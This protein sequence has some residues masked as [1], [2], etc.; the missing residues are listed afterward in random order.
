MAV[1]KAN[2]IIGIGKQSAFGTGVVPSVWIQALGGNLD[3][4]PVDLTIEEAGG[5]DSTAHETTGFDHTFEVEFYIR[6]ASQHHKLLTW[7]LMG[8]SEGGGGGPTYAHTATPKGTPVAAD[9]LSVSFD[10][11]A[12]V[13]AQQTL[14]LR[15]AVINEVVATIEQR[16]FLKVKLSGQGCVLEPV[17]G[18]LSASFPTE[19]RYPFENYDVLIA[20]HPTTPSSSLAKANKAVLTFKNNYDF[21]YVVAGETQ[22]DEPVVGRFECMV[23]LDKMVTASDPLYLAM[24]GRTRKNVALTFSQTVSGETHSIRADLGYG[25]VGDLSMPEV[26]GANERGILSATI[27]GQNDGSN[28]SLTVVTTDDAATH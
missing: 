21:S 26:S 11:G 8:L 10:Y 22:P 3:P 7:A 13:G 6:A 16:D 4:T 28:P 5:R 18:A 9:L 14:R 23:A 17:A 2:G 15:D 1:I 24:I 12:V 25:L 19:G 20:D 27:N